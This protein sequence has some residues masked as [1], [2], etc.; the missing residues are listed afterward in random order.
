MLQDA[1]TLRAHIFDQIN[2]K[3][4][5]KL[6]QVQLMHRAF[7]I[8]LKKMVDNINHNYIMH[9]LLYHISQTCLIDRI[10]RLF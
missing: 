5:R 3:L 1:I 2:R 10:L 7:D 9:C 6:Y 8:W 4:S